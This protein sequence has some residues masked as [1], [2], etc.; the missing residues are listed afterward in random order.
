LLLPHPSCM[1]CLS[2]SSSASISS[3]VTVPNRLPSRSFATARIWSLTATAGR[4]SQVIRIRI[5][6]LAFGELDNGTTIT[7]LRLS[8]STLT[9]TT[10]QGRVL[11]ISEP[12]VGSSA[13]HQISPRSGITS[14]VLPFRRGS[15]QSLSRSLRH[16]GP[17]SRPHRRVSIRDRAV[18]VWQPMLRSRILIGRV[19]QLDAETA[20]PRV[21]ER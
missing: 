2:P 21:R 18:P 16:Q 9:E 20:Q 12:S 19:M 1:I 17:D 3:P 14:T 10:T 8:F 6:G 7:V 4:P 15:R 11:R 13:S 5:G